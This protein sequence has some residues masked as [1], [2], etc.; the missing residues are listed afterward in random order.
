MLDLSPFLAL[1]IKTLTIRILKYSLRGGMT[2]MIRK[3][4]GIQSRSDLINLLLQVVIVTILVA[5]EVIIWI[6]LAIIPRIIFNKLFS[7]Y[8]DGIPLVQKIA[9]ND[10]L[11]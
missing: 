1:M 9:K 5:Q 10:P 11:P 7:K 8:F 2:E 3:P 4:N 6:I